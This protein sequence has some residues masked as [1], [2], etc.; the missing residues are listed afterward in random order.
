MFTADPIECQGCNPDSITSE[1]QR[2]SLERL[3]FAF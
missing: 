1:L 3:S 2:L